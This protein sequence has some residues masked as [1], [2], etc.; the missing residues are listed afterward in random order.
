M[1]SPAKPQLPACLEH[2]RD[3]R[4]FALW[5]LNR[6]SPKR[7][8]Q[9]SESNPVPASSADPDTWGTYSE[10]MKAV[11]AHACGF[12]LMLGVVEGD[13]FDVVALDLDDCRDPETG[14]LVPWA[15]KLV[16]RAA[17][18]TEVTPSGAGLRILGT[19]P[20]SLSLQKTL[21]RPDGGKVEVFAHGN[22]FIT[23]TGE[24]LNDAPDELADISGLIQAF[25]DEAANTE[26]PPTAAPYDDGRVARWIGEL[27]QP[28]KWHN[29]MVRLVAHFVECGESDSAIQAIAA[30]WTQPGYTEE[31]THKEVQT[32]IKGA[33]RKGFDARHRDEHG[34]SPAL[35]LRY[36]TLEELE[37]EPPLRML[38]D[39]LF[40]E[41]G[42]GIVA[43]PTGS[44]KTFLMIALCLS[45]ALGRKV[46]DL[47]VIQRDVLYLLNEGQAGF[48]QR[49]MAWLHHHGLSAPENFWVAKSTPDLMRPDS[50][51]PFIDLA[52]EIGVSPKLIVLDTFS[53]ATL[54]ADDNSTSDMANAIATAYRIAEHFGA[55]VVLI[56][57]VGKDPGRGVR[58][59]YAKQANVDMV[60][61]VHKTHCVWIKTT[62][63]KE[64][65]DNK[66][67]D[68]NVK[69]VEVDG[70][71]VP[72]LVPSS[73]NVQL[74]PT[75]LLLVLVD[76]QAPQ[77]R[78][79]LR[80]EFIKTL[81]ESSK[82]TFKTTF[83]RLRDD[84]RIVQRNGGYCRGDAK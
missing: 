41:K 33:R 52:E 74:G 62:K 43:G 6:N 32:A 44:M 75:D 5:D 2:H 22:R 3:K 12:G 9:C 17:S 23:V 80:Q 26:T 63:Q 56:D 16:R 82:D 30:S 78:E 11:E 31:Q 64:A 57:H 76:G 65:E 53:K 48:A 77:T 14:K 69:E 54:G 66:R 71:T 47:S 1:I 24:K 4:R 60:G 13:D 18:Y 8:F 28:G 51:R 73:T 19:C 61:M 10:A 38:I 35:P 50:I 84:G 42:V 79:E 36:Y 83:N 70:Q 55:F 45:V 25:M 81:G 40:P 58:G 59:A 20:Q 39:G 46:G 15:D 68:F 37:N 67:F 29:A 34:H 49:C 72:V 27:C 7:P 21:P